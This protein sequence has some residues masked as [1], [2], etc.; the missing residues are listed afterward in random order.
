[1]KT[2]WRWE[3]A[4]HG[5]DYGSIIKVMGFLEVWFLIGI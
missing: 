1:M 4:R 5:F 2:I 3:K